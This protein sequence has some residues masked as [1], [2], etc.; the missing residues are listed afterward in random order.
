MQQL[1][2]AAN[3]SRRP[4]RPQVK[5]PHHTNQVLRTVKANNHS[6]QNIRSLMRPDYAHNPPRHVRIKRH[7]TPNN[8][9]QS[10]TT[11]HPPSR[12]NNRRRPKIRRNINMKPLHILRRHRI[13]QSNKIIRQHRSSPTTTTSQ[14]NLNHSLSPHRR[15][16]NI[17][18]I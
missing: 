15:R 18:T 13:S 6:S 12:P 16:I 7:P 17:Q 3:V 8:P 1:P 11:T 9:R 14:Q 2:R 4:T 10:T 5:I